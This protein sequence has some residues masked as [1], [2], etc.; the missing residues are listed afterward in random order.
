MKQHDLQQ[1]QDEMH[2]LIFEVLKHVESM[3]KKIPTLQQTSTS[4]SQRNNLQM[5]QLS[6]IHSSTSQS[7]TPR[8]I[9]PQLPL[10]PSLAQNSVEGHFSS[11]RESFTPRL[12]LTPAQNWL[13]DF[14]QG[15]FAPQNFLPAPTYGGTVNN[16]FATHDNTTHQQN[17]AP[18][19]ATL[20]TTTPETVLHSETILRSVTNEAEDNTHATAGSADAIALETPE[21]LGSIKSKSCSRQNFA[22]NLTRATFLLRTERFLM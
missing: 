1:K 15:P 20:E 22:V 9:I 2:K 10:Q 16:V 13:S 12:Q 5:P 17:R 14:I 19:N 6:P 18:N 11:A 3:E 4:L 7:F 8:R 21:F